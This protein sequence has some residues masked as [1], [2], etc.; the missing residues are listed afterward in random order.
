[1]NND[2]AK[3]KIGDSPFAESSNDFYFY[4]TAIVAVL[5]FVLLAFIISQGN[6]FSEYKYVVVKNGVEFVSN[7]APPAELLQSYRDAPEFIVSPQF[8]ESG[9]E[10]AYMTSTLTVLNMVL[11]AKGKK[12]TVIG[13]VLDDKGSISSCVSNFGDPRVG[14]DL[15]AFECNNLFAEKKGSVAV[16]VSLPDQKGQLPRIVLDAKTVTI[17]PTSFEN[18]YYAAYS[19]AS[20]LYPDAD[21]I[22]EEVNSIV[23]KAS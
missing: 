15:N 9:P 23:R 19:F 16:Y 21:A 1:M 4:A 11:V 13:R 20:S 10:N 7:S 2:S 12:V 14:K 6:V 17:S 18:T 8:V 3:R 22:I 5:I